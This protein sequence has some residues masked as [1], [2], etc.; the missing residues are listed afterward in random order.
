MRVNIGTMI[1]GGVVVGMISVVSGFLYMLR[2][3]RVWEIPLREQANAV[4]AINK[5]TLEAAP[6]FEVFLLPI[7]IP[8]IVFSGKTFFEAHVDVF[9]SAEESISNW[10]GATQSLIGFVGDKNIALIIAVVVAV[11][12]LARQ[13]RKQGVKDWFGGI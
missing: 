6:S 3:N 9:S 13:Q 8:V 11:A 4:S 1:L 10:L 12:T 2:A 7:L 5:D